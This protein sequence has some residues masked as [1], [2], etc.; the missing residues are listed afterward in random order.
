MSEIYF[1]RH[2]QAS[3]G[4]DNY[5]QLSQ[6]GIHQAE[7]LARFLDE[8]GIHFNAIYSGT[9]RR[10]KDT[11]APVCRRLSTLQ[12]QCTE[13][14]VLKAFDEYNSEAL[15]KARIRKA[16]AQGSTADR[17]KTDLRRDQRAFQAYFSETVDQ[18]MAGAYDGEAG[19]EPWARFCQR[20]NAAVDQIMAEQGGGKRLAVFTSGGPISV[21]MKNVLGLSNQKTAE[22]SWQIQNA[23]LTC[24]KYNPR[25]LS[26]TVFNNTSHL[27][28]EG[29]PSLLTHR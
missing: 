16:R 13:P 6:I 11:A 20:V 2:G 14:L 27:M 26:L 15:I 17:P 21:V 5:D 10:Q 18:W 12:P 28:I 3:F 23:S 1:I 9:M 7:V 22:I 29:D 25:K 4:A 19:V 24:L 8:Q